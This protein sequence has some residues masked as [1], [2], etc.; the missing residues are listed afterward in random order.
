MGIKSLSL[1]PVEDMH[2]GIA[3]SCGHGVIRHL[4]VGC[5]DMDSEGPSVDDGSELPQR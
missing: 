1:C 2:H 3:I 4:R 5:R